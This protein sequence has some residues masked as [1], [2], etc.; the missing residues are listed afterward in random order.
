MRCT[1]E[2]CFLVRKYGRILATFLFKKINYFYE[3][4]CK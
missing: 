4:K 1:W 2:L 3:R